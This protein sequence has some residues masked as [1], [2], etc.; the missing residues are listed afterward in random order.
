MET[1]FCTM[2]S[3]YWILNYL[4]SGVGGGIIIIYTPHNV[5]YTKMFWVTT[6]YIYKEVVFPEIISDIL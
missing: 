1:F 4:L 3:H 2:L 6:V 5:W